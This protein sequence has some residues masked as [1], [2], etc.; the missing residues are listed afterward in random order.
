M[1]TKGEVAGADPRA[2]RRHADGMLSLRPGVDFREPGQQ[3]P[4]PI[5]PPQPDAVEVVEFRDIPAF[6]RRPQ[7]VVLSPA[8]EC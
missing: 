2:V 7:L 5:R 1:P 8:G 3:L 6:L 4:E